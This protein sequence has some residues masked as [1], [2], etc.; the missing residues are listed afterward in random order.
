MPRA[1]RL[2]EVRIRVPEEQVEEARRLLDDRDDGTLPGLE[3]GEL[4]GDAAGRRAAADE[5]DR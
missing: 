3:E 5:L 4:R 2:G 1:G